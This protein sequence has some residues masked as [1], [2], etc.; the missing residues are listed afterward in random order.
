MRRTLGETKEA[1]EFLAKVESLD[2]EQRDEFARVI[3]LLINCFFEEDCKAM[4]VYKDGEPLTK[5]MALN[6]DE[7]EGAK[8]VQGL[9]E[10]LD[11]VVTS[12]APPKEMF[13]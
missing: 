10:Y 2:K 7:M 13:N 9:R 12:D 8:M 5:V 3:K 6:C 4:V 1:L 11:F